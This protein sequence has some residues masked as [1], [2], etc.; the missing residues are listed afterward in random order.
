MTCARKN[1]IIP[2]A[3]MAVIVILVTAGIFWLW[4]ANAPLS[5]NAGMKQIALISIP[6]T[7]SA[8]LP[9]INKNGSIVGGLARSAEVVQ[10]IRKNYDRSLPKLQ[11]N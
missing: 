4:S 1:T 11:Y 10:G 2:V 6:D 8:V 5:G 9:H 7:H 3:A